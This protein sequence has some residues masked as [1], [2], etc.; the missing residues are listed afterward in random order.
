MPREALSRRRNPLEARVQARGQG[1]AAGQARTAVDFSSTLGTLSRAMTSF[2]TSRSSRVEALAA[3]YQSG[4]YTPDSM[5]VSR[6][7]ISEALGG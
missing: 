3:Q 6:G 4:N 2:D 7:L 5:A 1:P